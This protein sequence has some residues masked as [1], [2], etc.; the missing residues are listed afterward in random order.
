MSTSLYG[1]SVGFI[2]FSGGSL[3][4]G[5]ALA[6]LLNLILSPLL[7]TEAGSIAVYTS[8]ALGIRLPIAAISV[9]LT[10]VGCVGLYIAQAHRLRLGAVAFLLAGAGGFMAFAVEC[11]QFTLVRDIAFQ[12]PEALERLEAAGALGRYDLGFMISIATFAVGW[13]AVA[14]VT[15]RTG[16]L[17]RRGAFALLAGLVLLPIL[18][19]LAGLWGAVAGNVVLGGGWVLLGLDLVRVTTAGRPTTADR[20]G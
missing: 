16:V 15:L 19:G 8:T 3:V 18:G 14:I 6:A 7:P 17:G 12:A 1:T 13:L 11:V 9:A 4:L 10:T 5:G 2:R 20:A